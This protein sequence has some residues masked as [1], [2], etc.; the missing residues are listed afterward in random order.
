[1]KDRLAPG[2]GQGGVGAGAATDE[3]IE[4]PQGEEDSR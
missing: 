3:A 2:Q 4:Q 1:M